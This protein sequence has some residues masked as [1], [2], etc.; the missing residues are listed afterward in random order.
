[1]MVPISNTIITALVA[2]YG[3]KNI[4]G[5]GVGGRL[6]PLALVFIISLSASVTPFVGQNWGAEKYERVKKSIFY[7]VKIALIWGLITASLLA[8]FATSISQLFSKDILVQKTIKL[9]L[10]TIPISYGFYGTVSLINASLNAINKPYIAISISS[11]RLFVFYIPLAWFGSKL[12]QLKG[13]FIGASLGNI[14]MGII[15]LWIM[16]RVMANVKENSVK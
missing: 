6:E 16:T 2:T 12:Y 15:S 1:M 13:L 5:Y 9:Y 10:W 7:A 3:A 14:L 8:I 4:A 11:L